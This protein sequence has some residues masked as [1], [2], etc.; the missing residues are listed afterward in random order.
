M[1]KNVY[2]ILGIII[3]F[4]A[5]LILGGKILAQN[6]DVVPGSPQDPLVAKSYVDKQVKVVADQVN[7]LKARLAALEKKIAELSAS[8]P[9]VPDTTR[10]GIVATNNLYL[11]K[12][13][14]VSSNNIIAK[15]PLNTRLTVYLNKSTGDWYYVKTSSGKFGYVSKKYVKLQ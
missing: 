7:D 2:V 1:K 12:T 9:A 6:E 5:G 8:N 10:V 14:Q 15:L 4:T 13:P 3:A 11:R